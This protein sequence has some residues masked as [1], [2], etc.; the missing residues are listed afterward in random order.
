MTEEA[1]TSLEQLLDVFKRAGL[2]STAEE[3]AEMLW[4]AAQ[5]P[6]AD[7]ERPPTQ[8]TQ[9]PV[10]IP[11]EIT[12]TNRPSLPPGRGETFGSTITASSTSVQGEAEVANLYPIQANIP[13][14]GVAA[15]PIRSP[16]AFALPGS[17]E[18]GRN[19]RPF[20]RRVPSRSH[21]VLDEL[22]T[23]H[24]IADTGDWT[25]VLNPA[26]ERW[27]DVLLLVEETSSMI[28]WQRMVAELKHVLEHQG[29]FRNIEV[30]GFRANAGNT[31][32][33][34]YTGTGPLASQ[35]SPRYPA[36]LLDPMGRRLIAVVSDCV[37]PIWHN[38]VMATNLAL[39]G[40]SG[41]VT[42]IQVLPN[43]LWVRTGLRTYPA[44]YLCS[45]ASGAPNSQFE[46]EWTVNRPRLPI[47]KGIAVPVVT[48]EALSLDYWARAMAGN[49]NLWIPGVF[50]IPAVS[51][52][53]QGASRP[54]TPT[55]AAATA[56]PDQLVS[57]FYGTASPIARRLASYLA[58]VPLT[59]PIIRLV[60]RALLPES[61]QVHLAEVWLSG[62]INRPS[63]FDAT[64]SADSVEYFFVEGVRDQLQKNL[65]LG[66]VIDVLTM[67]SSHIG[68]R[69]GQPLDF[70]ALI[71][72]P[73]A[74]GD[75]Q[76]APGYQSFAQLAPGV[77]RRFGGQYADLAQRLEVSLYG[78]GSTATPT[79]KINVEREDKAP[80][81]R[82]RSGAPM[83]VRALLAGVNEH[84]SDKLRSLRGAVNDVL[85]TK[86]WLQEQCEVS[87]EN[88]I[89]LLDTA[90][91]K[92]A[93]VDSWHQIAS[94]IEEGD[95][96]F[97]HFVGYDQQLV[98]SDPNEA[99][100]FDETLVVYDS[101]PG[102]RATL[103]SHQELADLAAE[104]EAH[105]GQVVMLLDSCRTASS[106]WSRRA[107]ANTLVFAGAAEGRVAYEAQLGDGRHG[108]MTYFLSEAM[109]TFKPGMTWLDIYDYVL[110]HIRTRFDQTPQLI[111]AGDL[112][113]FGSERKSLPPYLLVTRAD[114]REIGIYAP[115]ALSLKPGERGA[116]LAIYPPGSAMDT[117][118]IAFARVQHLTDD[119]VIASLESPV[120]V[121]IAS[122]VRVLE[123]GDTQPMIRVGLDDSLRSLVQPS[124]LV[125]YDRR[126]AEGIDLVVSIEDGTYVI[127]DRG[128][129]IVWR[130]QTV[131]GI[132]VEARAANILTV[133]DH[134]ATYLRT[135]KLNNPQPV[136]DLAGK[137][138]LEV[139]LAT[140]G[141]VVTLAEA[142]PLALKLS[143]H[144]TADLYVSVWML[145]G[146]LGIEQVFPATTSCV[147][148]GQGREIQ[149]AVAIQPNSVADHPLRMTF[150][151]FASA[152]PADLVM[153]S[154][155][156]LD[157]S[158]DL[159]DLLGASNPVVS[160]AEPRHAVKKKPGAGTKT[161][162]GEEQWI[163]GGPVAVTAKLWKPGRTLRIKFLQGDP[164]VQKKVREAALEWTRYANLHFEFVS[165]GD[166]E[167]RISFEQG[168]SWSYVGTDSLTT[169]QDKPTI[170]LGWLT[171]K[172]TDEEI[173][174]VVIHEFG[175]TLG[176]VA[177]NQSPVANI[178]WNKKAAYE[179][180]GKM[181]WDRQTVDYNVFTKYNPDQ[182]K[183]GPPDPYSIM[184]HPVPREAT[185]G[186][187]EIFQGT[188]LSEG[189][190]QFIAQLYP[191]STAK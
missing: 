32:V 11:P 118:P 179:Y 143:N 174:R 159:G 72:D 41:L 100:G 164:V 35:S 112:V 73:K 131:P 55:R 12:E 24:Y 186:K 182:V 158:V 14:G 19:L 38:G 87:A 132:S 64:T 7:V 125:D 187:L 77:L 74:T 181:G 13:Q 30:L 98:S 119:G 120:T 108:A 134:I 3:V 28:I 133:L 67:V 75:V 51:V 91:T 36:E 189:D 104:V 96:F 97:F 53:T 40:Q 83:T 6:A 76:I 81:T 26:P 138:D 137:V 139:A 43:R 105:G 148:L 145:D 8:T 185:D 56:M 160:E 166:S 47:P 46:I 114:E 169:P 161:M 155:A 122:R 157:Q 90:A 62:L 176:L 39:W 151:V 150:K 92:Q 171:A 9:L 107:L 178:P 146:S 129:L 153:L 172:T 95:Q 21:F 63:E 141:D 111:G 156:R 42:L 29:A 78:H 20:K 80:H 167:L 136:S 102:E 130:E 175:H 109:K 16:A 84:K 5:L 168:G 2:E 110:A 65:R 101:L 128:G 163:P 68:E 89:T 52:Q 115:A 113:V 70:P 99:D 165:E 152:E 173:R 45:P 54:A 184:Y 162:P 124:A 170:N 127:E 177:A 121:P 86:A 69:I 126:E 140:S 188:E 48:L 37:S 82:D 66:E 190:K 180:Y 191:Y 93:I 135:F 44:I 154:L 123:Y 144:S 18:I 10:G 57:L 142:E 1:L 106:L 15:R 103:L 117:T 94:H 116:R 59:L 49:S 50:A 149:L 60:Q 34:F 31:S 27:L 23:A 25:P 147:L 71:A 17:L 183:Y 22:A 61:R 79:S 85:L 88:M 58:A 33:R 4:L